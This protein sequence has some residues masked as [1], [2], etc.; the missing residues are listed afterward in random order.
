MT[1]AC[2]FIVKV[3]L[4]VIFSSVSGDATESV[5]N[6]VS[7]IAEKYSNWALGITPSSP[8]IQNTP[9]YYKTGPVK[10][11]YH[12]VRIQY[13]LIKP[14]Q[15]PILPPQ[16]VTIAPF[17]Y[18][19]QIP[20]PIR[21]AELPPENTQNLHYPKPNFPRLLESDIPTP[22]LPVFP[23][24]SS[25]LPNHMSL[26]FGLPTYNVGH[27]HEPISQPK[28]FNV[29]SFAPTVENQNIRDYKKLEKSPP[30]SKEEVMRVASQK[31]RF[32]MPRFP[33]PMFPSD[34]FMQRPHCANGWC[35]N[36]CCEPPLIHSPPVPSTIQAT[37][38]PGS[39]SLPH[40]LVLI[41]H[42]S[43]PS[44]VQCS[45]FCQPHCNP[46]CLS[47]FQESSQFYNSILEP[48]CRPDCM[49]SC[50]MDCLI[51]PPQQIRCNSFNCRCLAGYVQC[52]A[53]TCCMRYPNMAARMK[54]NGVGKSSEERQ[55]KEEEDD[56]INQKI[57][58]KMYTPIRV[59]QEKKSNN[60]RGREDHEII[61]LMPMMEAKTK[62]W[63]KKRN[64]VSAEQ[65]THAPCQTT[66]TT[67][68]LTTSTT[69]TTTTT[70]TT[71][72]PPPSTTMPIT[73][74]TSTTAIPVILTT[75][76][77]SANQV[78][79][80]LTP[81]YP[82]MIK[83]AKVPLI[84]A[85]GVWSLPQQPVG[86]EVRRNHRN[87]VGDIRGRHVIRSEN[88]LDVLSE[89]AQVKLKKDIS[90]DFLEAADF[91]E[92]MTESIRKQK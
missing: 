60:G 29:N 37:A 17:T 64:D 70:T 35:N 13:P 92:F 66:T 65:T 63:T 87:S 5:V 74:T 56:E 47:R 36:D 78:T 31:S 75:P 27:L 42:P 85:Y 26:P 41:V 51:I 62:Y 24:N 12:P 23:S 40:P 90:N 43:P 33:I 11:F 71:S 7:K 83:S 16:N 6:K 55:V 8:H 4:I 22:P 14:T 34:G 48:T 69:T 77:V 38:L 1:L 21:L 19:Q 2:I 81:I 86:N 54:S 72:E 25:V 91:I 79:M 9:R 52:A 57:T 20:A 84:P 32:G 50:H 80:N 73:T 46:Q 88:F 82:D 76:P 44:Q 45:S 68:I 3:V 15:S 39:D 59:T 67:P 18:Y 53:Y 49:P 30:I 28:L 89:L 58:K 10:K 61:T